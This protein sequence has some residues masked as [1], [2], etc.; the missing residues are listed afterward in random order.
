MV[1][2][3][4]AT[5]NLLHLRIGN[6]YYAFLYKLE[7]YDAWKGWG[8]FVILGKPVEGKTSTLRITE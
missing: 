3:S 1:M 6:R 4:F 2:W 8:P 7:K 5:W